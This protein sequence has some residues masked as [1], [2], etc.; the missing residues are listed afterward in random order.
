MICLRS[1][2]QITKE[3]SWTLR[4][5][6]PVKYMTSLFGKAVKA[7]YSSLILSYCIFTWFWKRNQRQINFFLFRLNK[8]LLIHLL[9][10]FHIGNVGTYPIDKAS[11]AI[12]RA[13][14]LQD[15]QP[16]AAVPRP[17]HST[18][19]HSATYVQTRNGENKIF[20]HAH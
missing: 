14:S 6:Q 16:K 13:S 11:S 7:Y 19:I 15:I 1:S 2:R 20:L 8:N 17:V 5:N 4:L 9:D 18:R 12:H 10:D 3:K